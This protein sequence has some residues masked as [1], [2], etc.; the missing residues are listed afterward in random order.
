VARGLTKPGTRADSVFRDLRVGDGLMLPDAVRVQVSRETAR[1][2]AHRLDTV[3]DPVAR[4][5]EL[6]PI[7]AEAAG[8]PDAVRQPLERLQETTRRQLLAEA[9]DAVRRPAEGG[10]WADAAGQARAWQTK[11]SVTRPAGEGKE[12][13]A[14]HAAVEVACRAIVEVGDRLAT[15]DAFR[16]ALD[17]KASAGDLA[18]IDGA[19][20]P[21]ALRPD[22][23]ALRGL[24]ELREA[25][26]RKWADAPDVAALKESLGRVEGVDPQA[27]KRAAL[28]LAVKAMIEGHADAA[29]KLM[30][31]DAPAEQA[32]AALRDLKALALGGGKVETW[33]AKA[34]D[35][36]RP[37][38]GLEPLV[39]EARREGWRPP[40]RGKASAGV[41]LEAAEKA[42]AKV[43]DAAGPKVAAERGKLD[44]DAAAARKGLSDAHARVMA[45]ELADRKRFASVEY[46]LGRRLTASERTTVRDW[47]DDGKPV[48]VVVPLLPAVSDE[49]RY[50]SEVA[51][52]LGRELTPEERSQ[53][54]ALRRDG[55]RAAE[56]VELLRS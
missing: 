10:R 16:K 23:E 28:D 44:A 11:L 45:P 19:R 35:G 36:P 29:L 52:L 53:A 37:P 1:A 33:P 6:K 47:I 27:A 25:A 3:R 41:P 17:P 56:A 55:R 49:E 20:L 2:L 22:Q 39:P 38:P 43:R 7:R 18:G 21:E 50:L 8:L 26:A 32:A 15:L 31:A 40:A 9:L 51:R 42:G 48:E 13:T 54:R 30:P 5:N 34:A 46:R 14:D 4:L 24:A 12:I